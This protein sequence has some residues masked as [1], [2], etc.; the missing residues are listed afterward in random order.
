[1]G[2][3]V[4][5]VELVDLRQVAAGLHG[6]EV[7]LRGAQHGDNLVVELGVGDLLLVVGVAKESTPEVARLV[8]QALVPEVGITVVALNVLAVEELSQH[9]VADGELV[10]V[11][12]SHDVVGIV[13]EPANG[14]VLHVVLA[15]AE[16]ALVG[17]GGVAQLVVVQTT[18]G[19]HSLAVRQLGLDEVASHRK[20][21]LLVACVER[22]TGMQGTHSPVVETHL[23]IHEERVLLVDLARSIG[24]VVGIGAGRVAVLQQLL[25]TLNVASQLGSI[26]AE[27]VVLWNIVDA[28]SLRVRQFHLLLSTRHLSEESEDVE[29]TVGTDGIGLAQHDVVHALLTEDGGVGLAVLDNHIG[30]CNGLEEGCVDA[31][32]GRFGLVGGVVVQTQ[33]ALAVTGGAGVDAPQV[34]QV[35]D[36]GHRQTQT[37]GVLSGHLQV[38]ACQRHLEALLGRELPVLLLL[39]VRAHVEPVVT[40]GTEGADERECTESDCILIYL[41]NHIFLTLNS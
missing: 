13:S 37:V 23:A 3:H 1:M 31:L 18:E 10:L 34:G 17:T 11:I 21:R 8:L 22:H 4:V 29:L 9:L 25:G 40:A 2:Q 16:V 20:G 24:T 15:D 26:V 19:A 35:L 32:H 39:S 6:D 36:A 41:H 7:H 12:G 27:A 30:L 33:V 38:T 28:G 14:V 5:C